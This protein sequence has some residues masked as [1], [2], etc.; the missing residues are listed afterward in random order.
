MDLPK[1][2]LLTTAQTDRAAGVLLGMLMALADPESVAAYRDALPVTF[3]TEHRLVRA[4]LARAAC[5]VGD[6]ETARTVLEGLESQ[7]DEADGP[8]LLAR[9]NMAYFSG[10][11]D[12]AWDAAAAARRLRRTGDDPSQH[13][14]LLSLQGLIAHQRG[15]WFERF[16]REVRQETRRSTGKS[17]LATSLFDAHLCVAQYLLYGPVPY[18]EVIE[19]AES[20]RTRASQAG[21]PRGIAFATSMM[22]EAALLMGDVERAARE[23][24]EAVDLHGDLDAVTGETH[25]LQ[26]LAEVRLAQGNPDEAQRLLQRALPLAR[27][28]L[29]SKHLL[30]RIYGTMIASAR[31]PVSA[32]IIV[33]KAEATMGPG[34]ACPFC[35]IMLAVPAMIACA[36]VGDLENAERYL[37][38]AE[39]SAA[40]WEGT[41]WE[42][43]VLEGRAH[44]AKARG[45]GEE[46]GQLIEEATRLFQIAGQ[47]LDAARTEATRGDAKMPL[48]VT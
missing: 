23:L 3:G 26:R 39:E 7:G 35:D 19:L 14:D 44:L 8:I 4:R 13:F 43:A 6:F 25:G 33:D 34:D 28:L 1:T 37:R 24:Q 12:G 29:V 41:A 46:F 16:R 2:P 22:G 45:D 42:A 31:D 47:P 32:R 40:R 48:A 11:V 18:G 5:F 10:D 15:E 9:G 27:W 30:Q 38:V 21:V 36:D 20:L 17:G